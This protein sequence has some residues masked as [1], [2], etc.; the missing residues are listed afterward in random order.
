MFYLF[1]RIAIV[2]IA[3]LYPAYSTFKTLDRRPGYEYE[4]ERWLTYWTIAGIL[5]SLEYAVE[6]SISWFPFYWE[7]KTLFLIYLVLPQTQGSRLFYK[8]Y[9]RPQLRAYEPLIDEEIGTIAPRVI[10]FGRGIVS[11]LVGHA[12]GGASAAAASPEGDQDVSNGSAATSNQAFA[13]AA[14]IAQGLWNSY[15]PPAPSPAAPIPVSSPPLGSRQSSHTGTPTKS[16]PAGYNLYPPAPPPLPRQSSSSSA[17]SDAP[18][19]PIPSVPSA[20]WMPPA[21]SRASHNQ[22]TSS[23]QR[24]QVPDWVRR[25]RRQEDDE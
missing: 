6:W 5:F 19:F 7:L 13:M 25:S 16:P 3:F 21:P 22:R 8:A 14:G 15:A 18:S 4:A 23:Y 9:V 24:E 10:E 20:P 2:A 11:K 1:C 12:I 17:S